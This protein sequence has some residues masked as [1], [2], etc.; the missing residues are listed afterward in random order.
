MIYIVPISY[1]E[2]G[3]VQ[4]LLL[5]TTNRKWYVAYWIAPSQTSL[6]DPQRHSPTESLVTCDFSYSHAAV[7]KV[8]TDK[9][10]ARSLCNSWASFFMCCFAKCFR[11][12]T[13]AINIIN[14]ISFIYFKHVG[15]TLFLRYFIRF[16]YYYT[17]NHK[18][19]AFIFDYNFG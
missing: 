12:G 19:V 10:V 2:S 5:Y 9:R 1:K 3:R 11:D 16:E 18:N 8:L 13:L 6:S 15:P 14:C 17:V 7:G 4:T